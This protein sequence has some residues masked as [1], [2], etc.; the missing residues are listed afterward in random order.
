MR[1]QQIYF[2]TQ[3]GLTKP[4]E[5]IAEENPSYT[6]IYITKKECNGRTV[7]AL[8]KGSGDIL[9]IVSSAE[10]EDLK[11]YFHHSIPAAELQKKKPDDPDPVS[12]KKSKQQSLF[13]FFS[14]T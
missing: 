11:R 6:R 4:I 3:P 5:K 13:S 9:Y 10:Y 12:V 14:K 7:V 2:M 8:S 1:G